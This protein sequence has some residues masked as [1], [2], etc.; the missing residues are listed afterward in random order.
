ME[1]GPA[2]QIYTAPA[3]PYTQALLSAVPE[4]DPAIERDAAADRAAGRRAE[5]DQPAERLPVPHP[6]PEG[7]RTICAE[8][9]PELI[10]RGQGHPVACHFPGPI[11]V[12][13]ATPS[14]TGNLADV[15]L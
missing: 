15:A 4:P 8:E 2:E 1:I 5:P 3:H 9:E 11:P 10:D 13:V 12:S 6:L 14:L 7:A